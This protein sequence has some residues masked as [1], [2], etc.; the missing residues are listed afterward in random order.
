MEPL[1]PWLVALLDSPEIHSERELS[2][3]ALAHV[4][5]C[6]ACNPSV[7]RQMAGRIAAR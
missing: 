6:P 4:R 5:D 1:C 3:V 7:A 2:A